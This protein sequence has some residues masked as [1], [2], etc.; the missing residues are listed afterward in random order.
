MSRVWKL[1]VSLSLLLGFTAPSLLAQSGNFSSITAISSP[2]PPIPI[3]IFAISRASN[4]VTVSTTDP[5]NPDQ[6]GQLNKVGGSV[7]IAGVSVD[8]SNAVNG[9]FTICGPPVQGCAA[10]TTASFSYVS[11]GQNFSA[12]G[13][14]QLGVTSVPRAPC[15]LTPTGY[16]SFCG[17][18]RPGA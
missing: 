4:I 6:Y 12:S 17:D 14:Q 8:P 3:P 5:G 15:P 9:T 18:S 7:T 10:P 1:V 13:M 2:Q 16:F 11:A